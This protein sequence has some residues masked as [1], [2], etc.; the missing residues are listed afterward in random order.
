MN[1]VAVTTNNIPNL[2]IDEDSTTGP[3]PFKIRDFETA[4]NSLTVNFSS[5]NRA[6][7]PNISY[8]LT[9]IYPT[10]TFTV[11]PAANQFC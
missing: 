2:T 10:R 6:L 7:I 4:A 1:R 9:E 8:S 11:V 5:S 3:I